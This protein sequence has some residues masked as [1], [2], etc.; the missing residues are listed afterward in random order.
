[1]NQ[2]PNHLNQKI[3]SEIKSRL[4]PDLKRLLLKLFIIHLTTAVVT[5]S[6]CPQL[7][8][9]LFK[10]GIN[11][12]DVF[13]K[14]SPYFCDLACGAFFTSTSIMSALFILRRD[15]LRLLRHKKFL[16][17]SVMTLSSIGFLIMLGPQ[18]F[19]QFS[20]LWLIGSFG[21]AMLSLDLGTRA[22]KFS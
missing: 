16:T 10:T 3:L 12:M 13:M 22:M 5:L 15:E 21:G 6:I 17:T 9:S 20:L 18:F 8:F 19:I 7:G 2:V 1:M 14:I 11:L 4:H